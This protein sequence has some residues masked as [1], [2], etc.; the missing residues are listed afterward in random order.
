[1][2]AQKLCIA[3]TGHERRRCIRLHGS[4]GREVDILIFTNI[5]DFGSNLTERVYIFSLSLSL[6]FLCMLI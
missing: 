1:M 3:Y 6:F 4:I 5:H 2:P